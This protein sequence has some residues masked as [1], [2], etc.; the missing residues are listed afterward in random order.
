FSSPATWQAGTPVSTFQSAV[1]ATGFRLEDAFARESTTVYGLFAQDTWRPTS[2][3]TVMAGLRF[4]YPYVGAKPPFNPAF[5]NAFGFR[6]DTTYSGNYTISP[7]LGFNYMLSSR[8]TA[9]LR[10]GIGLF[11]GRNPAVWLINPYQNAGALGSI[12]AKSSQLPKGFA[13]D[14]DPYHQ[15][16]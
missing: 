10:G 6:N 15:P 16:T 7:R 14:P 8:H 2:R 9:Q 1:P 12:Q 3:L 11:Q 5:S 13:F 4:D